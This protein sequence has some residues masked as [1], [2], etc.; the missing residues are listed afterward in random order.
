LKSI[1]DEL[2]TDQYWHVRIGIDNRPG[3]NRPM[4][5]EYV[6]QNFSDEEKVVLDRV[7][8]EACHELISNGR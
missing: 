2:E 4:G 1:N 8:K 6:L 5:E 3:D 7:I